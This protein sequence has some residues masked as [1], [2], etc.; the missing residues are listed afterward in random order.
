MITPK[1]EVERKSEWFCGVNF[2]AL[3]LK[4]SEKTVLEQKFGFS[5]VVFCSHAA[6]SLWCLLFFDFS[7]RIFS[8]WFSQ[9][10]HSHSRPSFLFN[11]NFHFSQVVFCV[12][13]LHFG[14]DFLFFSYFLSNFKKQFFSQLIHSLF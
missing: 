4:Y 11:L 10:I 9:S 8:R 5:V 13:M 3:I 14:I 7:K 1:Q 12:H 2:F 6:I